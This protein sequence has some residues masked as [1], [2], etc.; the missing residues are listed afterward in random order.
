[1]N[2]LFACIKYMKYMGIPGE[3]S[4]TTKEAKS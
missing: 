3:M 2:R 4:S 1:M